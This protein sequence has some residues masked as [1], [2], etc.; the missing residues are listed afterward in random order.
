MQIG[1][2]A[3][4]SDLPR[5]EQVVAELSVRR[6]FGFAGSRASVSAGFEALICQDR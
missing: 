6:E 5:L 4:I 2:E 1:L 3:L